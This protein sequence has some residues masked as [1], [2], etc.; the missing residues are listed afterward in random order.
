MVKL[1]RKHRIIRGWKTK[2]YALHIFAETSAWKDFDYHLLLWQ[3]GNNCS[4]NHTISLWLRRY[5]VKVARLKC[6]TF[7]YIWII[8]SENIG[9]IIFHHNAILRQ[10]KRFSNFDLFRKWHIWLIDLKG[11]LLML[12]FLW[13][14]LPS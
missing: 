10:F 9:Y 3:F 4:K 5:I 2:K 13:I 6:T 11:K 14:F 1:H 12:K 7:S 8:C